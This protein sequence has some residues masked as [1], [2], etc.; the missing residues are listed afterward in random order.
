MS[1]RVGNTGS[2][3]TDAPGAKSSK[4]TKQ[5]KTRAASNGAAVASSSSNSMTT[6]SDDRRTTRS[7][8]RQNGAESTNRTDRIPKAQD[9]VAR[10]T[11]AEDNEDLR[12]TLASKSLQRK[13]ESQETTEQ[14]A[15]KI[16]KADHEPGNDS[17]PQQSSPEKRS[18]QPKDPHICCKCIDRLRLELARAK[19]AFHDTEDQIANLNAEAEQ[20]EHSIAQKD[21]YIQRLLQRLENTKRPVLCTAEDDH[22]ETLD[23]ANQRLVA[24]DKEWRRMFEERTLFGM[25]R[26]VDVGLRGEYEELGRRLRVAE[27]RV[28]VLERGDVGS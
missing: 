16:A 22:I 10:A 25:V 21:D 20:Y 3:E 24:R 5:R 8:S 11:A 2:S 18:K 15:K 27:E 23:V 13:A 26:P 6:P 17:P 1:G 12:R 9:I 28:R 4:T 7:I 14:P 19:D